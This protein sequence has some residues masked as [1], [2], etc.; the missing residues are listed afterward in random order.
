[1]ATS[2]GLSREALAERA[3]VA[4]NVVDRLADL[5]ILTASEGDS[6]FGLPDVYRIRLVL[7][8]ERAGLPVDAIGQA[9]AEGKISHS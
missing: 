5:G 6:P 7:A 9:I 3:G 1:M 2:S 4:P 8:C